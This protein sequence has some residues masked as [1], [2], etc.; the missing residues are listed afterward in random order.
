M[1]EHH[2]FYVLGIWTGI[3]MKQVTFVLL[4]KRSEVY[5]TVSV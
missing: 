4:L 2:K 1:Q 5:A 3:S